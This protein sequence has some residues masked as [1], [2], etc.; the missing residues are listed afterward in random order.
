MDRK[1]KDK[2]RKRSRLQGT[3]TLPAGQAAFGELRLKGQ[4]TLLR[5]KSDEMLHC[6]EAGSHL[7]GVTHERRKVTCID[8]LGYGLGQT[9]TGAEQIS[10]S[11]EVFPHFV[12]VGEEHLDPESASIHRIDFSVDD[13]PA[14]FFDHDAFGYVIDSKA[15]IDAV[16]EGARKIRKVE[17]GEWPL[18]A[19]F[20]GERT[21][22][23]VET[24][25][26]EVTISHRPSSGSDGPDGV[27]I[28]N[29][30]IA[31][32]SPH[33]PVTFDDAVE[34]M[35]VVARFLSI[36]AGR[37]QGVHDIQ[38][39][40]A[41]AKEGPARG[42]DLHWSYGW[43]GPNKVR[44]HDSPHPVAIPLDPVRRPDEFATVL[45]D[46]LR[47]D[48][49]WRVPRARYLSCMRKDNLYDAD[50][51]VAA[52]NMFDILPQEA[53]PVAN[54]L[55]PGLAR[56][57][58]ECMTILKEHPAGPDRDSVLSSFGRMGKPSLPKKVNHRVEIVVAALGPKFAELRFVAATAVKCRNYFVHGAS[59]DFDYSKVEHLKSFLCEALEFIFAASDLIEAGWDAGR[60]NAEAPG[61]GHKFARFSAN[62]EAGLRELKRATEK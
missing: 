37:Q 36:I 34:R 54:E 24:C 22:A 17:A 25:I 5:L 53:V 58:N 16:L 38:L 49:N 30:M 44:S 51:L 52:A 62:F 31:S 4:D 20:T 1:I 42:L 9:M 47:R 28:N 39:N 29:R 23:K 11:L 26:G 2:K 32:I 60:W 27:S 21:V 57:R 7:R 13:L 3:F 12:T 15:V 50:R 45:A 18:V 46:W 41:S 48:A 14:L 35:L 61:W 40:I 10:Y 19:Y 56:I 6:I 43:E 8:C 55:S 59:E 33:V